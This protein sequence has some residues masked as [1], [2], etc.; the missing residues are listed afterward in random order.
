VNFFKRLDADT[1]TLFVQE[2]VWSGRWE[3]RFPFDEPSY[4]GVYLAIIT[5]FM[6]FAVAFDGTI[7]KAG[8]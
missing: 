7:L 8:N 1:K 2:F 6:I 3:I 4:D 5:E